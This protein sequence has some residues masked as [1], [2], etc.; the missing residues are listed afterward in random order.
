MFQSDPMLSQGLLDIECPGVHYLEDS[1]IEIDGVSFWGSPWQPEFNHWA[2]NLY[3]GEQLAQKWAL[4]PDDTDVLITHGP[5]LGI[6]DFVPSGEHVGCEDLKNRVDQ[7][8][9]L[10]AHI[11]G[12]IHYSY[13][14]VARNGKYFVNAANCSEEYEAVNVP[15]AIDI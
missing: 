15:I 2:F 4:I 3:R 8:P 7:M 11:F 10:K 5:P 13:G 12:H 14:M 6:L 9:S 1:G